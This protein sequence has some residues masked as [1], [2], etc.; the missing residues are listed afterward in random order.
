MLGLRLDT[1]QTVAL[2]VA[3]AGAALYLA[4]VRKSGSGFLCVLSISGILV[5][6]TDE[7][8]IDALVIGVLGILLMGA[9]SWSRRRME[10]FE[11][12]M[13]RRRE[14]WV[15]KLAH[16]TRGRDDAGREKDDR[17][18]DGAHRGG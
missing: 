17:T 10:K 2:A 8:Q 3:F 15:D 5:G 18:R 13:A 4:A 9:G 12:G 11:L 6:L 7:R 1:W 14:E 16:T